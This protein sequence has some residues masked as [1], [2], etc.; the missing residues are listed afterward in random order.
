MIVVGVVSII[1]VPKVFAQE[2]NQVYLG[3]GLGFDYGGIGAKIEYM[4]V[5]HVGIVG[6]LGYNIINVSWNDGATY[7][8]MLDKK[9]YVIPM[10]YYG[11][12]G[13]SKISGAREY[14]MISYGFT[15]GLNVAIKTGK[16]GNKLS[17]GLF[18]PFRSQKFMDNYDAI[19][20]DYRIKIGRAHV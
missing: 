9:V 13:G 15:A 5:K 7:K 8:I 2:E 10:V 16:K 14:D 11:Y 19:K 17:A 20:N 6:S 3:L 18:V 12:N 4:P 1:A